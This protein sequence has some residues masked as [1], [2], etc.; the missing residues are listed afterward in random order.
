MEICNNKPNEKSDIKMLKRNLRK[1]IRDLKDDMQEM[2]AKFVSA[3]DKTVSA[4]ERE[5]YMHAIKRDAHD[6]VITEKI[7]ESL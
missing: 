3:D 2:I 1:H 5:G 4:L 6:I 7:L